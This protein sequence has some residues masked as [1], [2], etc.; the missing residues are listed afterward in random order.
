MLLVIMFSSIYSLMLIRDCQKIIK[1]YK[2]Q[3]ENIS[4]RWLVNNAKDNFKRNYE[5]YRQRKQRSIVQKKNRNIDRSLAT[6]NSDTGGAYINR[7]RTGYIMSF[8]FNLFALGCVI[9]VL[10]MTPIG[11][12]ILS[13]VGL[14]IVF[15]GGLIT[16]LGT[17]LI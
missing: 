8:I 17:L 6:N 12:T 9:F 1:K 14:G 7:V 15:I 11:A 3:V 5:D 16:A 13:T 4:E 2:K 10:F